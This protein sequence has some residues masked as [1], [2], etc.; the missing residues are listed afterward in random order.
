MPQSSGQ[1]HA[2]ALLF[3]V[4]YLHFALQAHFFSLL[5]QIEYD[6]IFQHL[7]VLIGVEIHNIS[8]IGVP[9]CNDRRLV[10]ILLGKGAALF[11][12]VVTEQLVTRI[13]MV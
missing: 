8:H 12:L 13:Q 6:A 1:F 3:V 9:T 5:L 2:F 7:C 11:T 4:Y 10:L